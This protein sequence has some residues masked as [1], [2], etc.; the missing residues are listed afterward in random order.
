[1][2]S[3]NRTVLNLKLRFSLLD[4]S[5]SNKCF[6]AKMEEDRLKLKFIKIKFYWKIVPGILTNLAGI[7]DHSLY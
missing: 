5:V 6:S 7:N 2:H 3:E 1:M 4:L